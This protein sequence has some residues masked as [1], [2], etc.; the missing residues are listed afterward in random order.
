MD[1]LCQNRKCLLM[2]FSQW[3]KGYEDLSEN[4]KFCISVPLMTLFF[5]FN[6]KH[7]DDNFFWDAVID[8]SLGCKIN[9]TYK[10]WYERNIIA[11]FTS[12]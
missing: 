2:T 10:P 8:A 1:S 7:G 6:L 5:H 4:V 9:H 11:Y 3:C 12:Y